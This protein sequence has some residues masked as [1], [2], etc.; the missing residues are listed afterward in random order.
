MATLLLQLLI[1]RGLGG[2][3]P[4]A[5]LTPRHFHPNADSLSSSLNLMEVQ[6]M[7]STCQALFW[8]K[9]PLDALQGIACANPLL[10]FSRCGGRRAGGERGCPAQRARERRAGGA[11]KGIVMSGG[12]QEH[13]GRE[14]GEAGCVILVQCIPLL[15]RY[16][17]QI[18][19]LS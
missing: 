6:V 3:S 10:L 13:A 8:F 16:A 12:A 5:R 11:V 9:K 18:L 19:P 14:G 2:I 1:P 17:V 15:T 7:K 4:L